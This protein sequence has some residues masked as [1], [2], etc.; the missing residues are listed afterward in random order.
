MFWF[1]Y[2]ME[3]AAR[4]SL[5]AQR[6]MMLSFLRLP[7]GQQRP[8][9]GTSNREEAP[10]VE[11]PTPS[12]EQREAAVSDGEKV[13]SAEMPEAASPLPAASRPKIASARKAAGIKKSRRKGKARKKR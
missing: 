7:S 12:G 9:Q 1:T 13:A 11:M 10:S 8:E 5:E 4:L 6:L 3:A 2:P